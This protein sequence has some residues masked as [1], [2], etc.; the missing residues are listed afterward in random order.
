MCQHYVLNT[1]VIAKIIRIQHYVLNTIMV[2]NIIIIFL[3][4]AV[5]L[6]HKNSETISSIELKLCIMIAHIN[7]S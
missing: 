1:I 7:V 2:A 4:L 6:A 3:F 5:R